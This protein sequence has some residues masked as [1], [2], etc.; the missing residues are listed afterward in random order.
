MRGPS[1]SQ[2][3]QFPATLK[4][5]EPFSD[6]GVRSQAERGERLQQTAECY[7]RFQTGERGAET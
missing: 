3:D 7:L 2:Y 6:D 5:R 1:G 4:Y